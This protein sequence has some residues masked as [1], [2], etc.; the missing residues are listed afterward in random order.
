MDGYQ[1]VTKLKKALREVRD[2]PVIAALT[3][4]TEKEFISR[5]L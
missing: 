3:G 4:H 1:L 5:A 2:K